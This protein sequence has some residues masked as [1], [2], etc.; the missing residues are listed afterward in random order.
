ME[1]LIWSY[2]DDRLALFATSKQSW[3]G[4]SKALP[5]AVQMI[6]GLNGVVSQLLESK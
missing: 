6:N 3:L 4:T 2:N 1:L 5:S